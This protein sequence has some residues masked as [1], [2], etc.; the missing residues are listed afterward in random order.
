[1]TKTSYRIIEGAEPQQRN[2]R[3]P[4]TEADTPI[5]G[6]ARLILAEKRT[7]LAAMRTGHAGVAVPL[8]V[9][10]L[11]IATSQYYHALHVLPLI[12]PPGL[13]LPAL[14]ALGSYLII[15]ALR[16]TQRCD[17]MICRIKAGHSKLSEFID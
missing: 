2:F 7:S 6:E 17:R 4:S 15:R 16:H 10:S 12:I 1:M 5:I 11:L 14:I 13:I 9:A 8:S 3:E